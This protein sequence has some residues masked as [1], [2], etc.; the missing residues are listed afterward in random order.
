MSRAI[1]PRRHIKV[2]IA[3]DHP[4]S[5]RGLVDLF[6]STDDIDV[7][8]EVD[9]GEGALELADSTDE[10]PDVI[11][12]DLRMP[13]L[14]GLE[15]TRRIRSTHP[16]IRVVILTANEDPAAMS[17]AVRAGA[18]AYVLKT[19]EGEQVLETVRMVAQ[20]HVVLDPVAWGRAAERPVPLGAAVTLSARERDV[21]SLLS[22]GRTNREI[23]RELGLSVETVKTHCER[24]YRRLGVSDRTDAVAKGLRGGIIE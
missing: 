19:A 24:L 7:V 1:L 18:S 16:D 15:A 3:E 17:E 20:G 13:R 23:A 9:D 11:V 2:G 22:Q 14:D 12:V 6:E 5:R 8:G 21:L 4:L 10:T